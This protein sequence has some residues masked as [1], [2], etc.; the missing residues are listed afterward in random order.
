MTNRNSAGQQPATSNKTMGQ[1]PIIHDDNGQVLNPITKSD[2][3]GWVAA[4]ATRNFMLQNPLLDWLDRY[5]IA[6][7]FKPD[8]PP[9]PRTDHV[10]FL[11]DKGRQFKQAV[12]K[13]LQN[14][15]QN[16]GIGTVQTVTGTKQR[17]D[18]HDLQAA[19]NTYQAMCAG[20]AVVYRGVLRDPQHRCYGSPDLLIRS[21]VL[22]SLFGDTLSEHEPA[23]SA[24]NL[25]IDAHYV[26]VDIKYTTLKLTTTWLL[27]SSRSFPAYK[28]QLH[29]YNRALGRLQ[30]FTPSQ[31]FLL[32]R[33]WEQTIKKQT[34]R[35]PSAM[36]RLGPVE[37]NGKVRN[38][39]VGG[40]V[41]AAVEWLLRMR[42]QGDTWT[43]VPPSV[44]ELR[45][46]MNADN[47]RWT[48]VTKA[49]AA[50]TGELT[51]LPNISVQQRT[52]ADA[53]GL[54]DWRDP[55][56]T[57][58]SLGVT[59]AVRS[60]EL[61]AVLD[62]NRTPGTTPV[63][64]A[65]IAVARGTWFAPPPLEFFVDFETVNNT[66][67]DFSKFPEQNGQ[68]LVFMV[69]CGHVEN[70]KWRFECFVA[71]TLSEKAEAAMLDQ[72]I[73]HMAATT[74][75]IAPGTN[76]KLI[77]WSNAEPL[78]LELQHNSAVNRHKTA[79]SAW[80]S[81]NWFDLLEKTVRKEPVVVNGAFS[82]NL[83]EFANALYAL[84]LIK[85]RWKAGLTDG[86]GAM[87]G[88]WWCQNQVDVG[89][90]Q[91]LID[92]GLMKVIR[93]YNE[94]DCRVMWEILS[95]LRANH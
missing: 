25:D 8:K 45:S 80:S 29:I 90:H 86:L 23:R 63:R 31:A 28:A 46:N 12:V 75:R 10:S 69:G 93:R 94:V 39:L 84:G 32:G 44:D 91:R 43:V 59:G 78:M 50:K 24:P 83:K 34:N 60:R 65:H 48:T 70:N 77:H 81:L 33:G 6:K 87:V 57:S 30:G 41:D 58:T 73:S 68:P 9:D 56:V 62:V 40:L 19:A 7:G 64:P 49:L 61:D 67:D 51:M 79:G 17:L 27:N 16:Q 66:D 42:V 47:G 74:N 1:R 52:K 88:A 54:T 3:D 15:L 5:G 95:Y 4:T 53:V 72:W 26:V 20:V 18:V 76:P 2:W 85:T 82:F 21:D 36:D 92:V 14:H 89:K 55:A 37:H 71:D 22:E 11:S 35:Q 13:H 38:Q